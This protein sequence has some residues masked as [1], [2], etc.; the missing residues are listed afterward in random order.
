MKIDLPVKIWEH[1]QGGK[2]RVIL[3][4]ILGPEQL[5]DKCRVYVKATLE[6]GCSMGTHTHIGDG[7]SYHILAGKGLYV[8]DGKSLVLAPGDSVFCPDG[9]SHSFENVGNENL[10]FMALIITK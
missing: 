6:P 3:Q 7:E 5:G 10:V 8:E 1:A 2:G 9:Y 4:P